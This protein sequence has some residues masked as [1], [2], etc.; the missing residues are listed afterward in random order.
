MKKIFYILPLIG[1]S[2]FLSSCKGHYRY[3]C[4]DPA[5]W[6]KAEC[7]NDVCKAQGTCTADVL[8]PAGSREF[9]FRPEAASGIVQE[10][11]F[12]FEEDENNISNSGCIE[13]VAKTPVKLSYRE[14]SDD[15][16]F[17]VKNRMMIPARD[18][19]V[20]EHEGIIRDPITLEE[21][22]TMNSIVNTAAHN[23]AIR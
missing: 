6:G 1:L 14:N 18:E 22:L 7:N 12:S 21:P 11:E 15:R 3:P 16:V 9:G 4:Q 23:A 13:P 17:N 2:F 8:A 19:I 20:E 10:E 5:N